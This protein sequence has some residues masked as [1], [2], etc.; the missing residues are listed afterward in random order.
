MG[1]MI[2][3]IIFIERSTHDQ[4][5]RMPIRMGFQLNL[6]QITLYIFVGVIDAMVI[7]IT[8]EMMGRMH[9]LME[10]LR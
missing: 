2:N 10:E 9:K 7:E 4:K 6:S 5:I 8:E 1:E 3:P